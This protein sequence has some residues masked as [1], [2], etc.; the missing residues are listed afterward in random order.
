MSEQDTVN[1]KQRLIG[2]II[3]VSLGV[4]LIPFLLNGGP[5]LKQSTMG[6]NIPSMP[7]K[8]D[9]QLPDIPKPAAMPAAKT[10][11]SRPVGDRGENLTASE[12]TI[13]ESAV[14]PENNHKKATRPATA[15]ID[16]AFT[17]QIASFSQLSN[18]VALRDKLRKAKYNAYIESINIKKGKIYRLRVGPYLKYAQ[19]SAIQKQLEKQFNLHKTVIVQYKT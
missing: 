6:S 8:L 11:T 15:K 12:K 13:E 2:A 10:I 4:I 19:I 16:T 1:I 18:A 9:R 17:L 7:A 3:L 14:V 5:D